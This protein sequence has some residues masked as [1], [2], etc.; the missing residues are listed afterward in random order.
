MILSMK[1]VGREEGV[2]FSYGGFVGNT[3]DS[4]RLICLVKARQEGGSQLQDFSAHFENEQS[5]GETAVL[6]E[7]A[8]KTGMDAKDLFQDE[9]IGQ[10]EVQ[11]EM[12]EFASRWDCRGA[13][14]SGRLI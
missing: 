8:N 11:E 5:L 12:T 13:P 9:S 14:L 3:F 4:H 6:K 7:C 1:Q 10:S 2:H